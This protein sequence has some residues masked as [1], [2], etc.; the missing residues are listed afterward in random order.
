M[1]NR[2]LTLV[3]LTA[4]AGLILAALAFYSGMPLPTP[5]SW[6]QEY[7]QHLHWQ[8]RF[9]G[10]LL[11][12]G[13]AIG[14]FAWILAS[15]R[16]PR[17]LLKL[18]ATVGRTRGRYAFLATAVLYLLFWHAA[19]DSKWCND[20]FMNLSALQQRVSHWTDYV[21]AF[22]WV[23]PVDGN[24]RPLA[25]YLWLGFCVDTSALLHCDPEWFSRFAQAGVLI[26][27]TFVLAKL[28]TR[29]GAGRL[30]T[31]GIVVLWLSRSSLFTIHHW[32]AAMSDVFSCL[33]QIS[34]F[35]FW[36]RFRQATNPEQAQAQKSPKTLPFSVPAVICHAAALLAKQSALVFPCVIAAA[37][38]FLHPGHQQTLPRHSPEHTDQ[39]DPRTLFC[40]GREAVIQ[41]VPFALISILLFF[42]GQGLVRKGTPYPVLIDPFHWLMSGA[43]F[44]WALSGLLPHFWHPAPLA[45]AIVSGWMGVFL[46]ALLWKKMA[47]TTFSPLECGIIRFS[48]FAAFPYWLLMTLMP[49]RFR[50]YY[51]A[52]A[53]PWLCLGA[54]MVLQAC[55]RLLRK[56]PQH[57]RLW[58]IGLA[59]ISLIGFLECEGKRLDLL[60]SGGHPRGSGYQRFPYVTTS[61]GPILQNATGSVILIDF[62]VQRAWWAGLVRTYHPGVSRV[63]FAETPNPS[64]ALPTA[65]PIAWK[66][67][68][69]GLEGHFE[70]GTAHPP[71]AGF[72]PYHW[73]Q[74]LDPERARALLTDH[75]QRVTAVRFINET[76]LEPANQLLDRLPAN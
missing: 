42:I 10:F 74:P 72:H 53:L 12:S 6:I 35:F 19:L 70:A 28:A 64:P 33:G 67:F 32:T 71:T 36:F 38:F 57:L 24:Y 18:V 7:H 21:R 59:G 65:P 13:I 27:L 17:C 2:F 22:T 56:N 45:I 66:W 47:G 20:D 8:A 41:A 40:R 61:L 54:G 14:L 4:A 55:L 60:Y 23:D 69:N 9:P 34:A 3:C 26:L 15:S 44:T 25:T 29:I 52:P 68:H 49:S 43:Y 51:L 62:P 5:P 37:E 1:V 58:A 63:L 46:L 75:A 31:G 11:R 30:A 73:E 48:L 39:T 16:G 50:P 76:R